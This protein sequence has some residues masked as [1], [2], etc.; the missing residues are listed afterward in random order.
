[1][2]V[3]P[4]FV[5]SAL[6]PSYHDLAVFF[7][8]N[9]A[10]CLHKST[11]VRRLTPRGGC[12]HAVDIGDHVIRGGGGNAVSSDGLGVTGKTVGRTWKM[13]AEA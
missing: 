6:R 1:M 9:K 4:S 12:R 8:D 13:G 2:L 10:I 3:A 11:A 5:S 7:S